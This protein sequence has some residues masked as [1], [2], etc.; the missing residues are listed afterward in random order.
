M[1]KHSCMT[2]KIFIAPSRLFIWLSVELQ[3][4]KYFSLKL[5][6]ITPMSS[7]IH[8]ADE[9]FRG[10]IL[11]SLG[12]TNFFFWKFLMFCLCFWSSKFYEDLWVHF[13]SSWWHFHFE[14]LCFILVRENF[15]LF[16]WIF[17]SIHCL[18]SLFL[19]FLFTVSSSL[20]FWYVY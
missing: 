8:I 13:N 15:L 4:Q 1:C 17:P 9:K 2:K 18:C 10:L 7:V 12:L 14:E 20:S 16:I 5:E 6:G 19:S 3:I 11:V